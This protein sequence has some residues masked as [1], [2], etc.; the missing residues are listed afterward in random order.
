MTIG[1]S[2]RRFLKVAGASAVACATVSP[3]GA[4]AAGSPEPAAAAMPHAAPRAFPGPRCSAQA[5][6]NTGATQAPRVG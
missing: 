2:R 5:Y 4:L 3:R 1:S 6:I